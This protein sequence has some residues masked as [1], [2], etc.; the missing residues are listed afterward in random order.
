MGEDPLY[1][2][3]NLVEEVRGG[4]EAK[5]EAGIDIVLLPPAHTQKRPV[6]RMHR[7]HPECGLQV[8]LGHQGSWPQR[9]EDPHGVVDRGVVE[10]KLVFGDVVVHAPAGWRR[11]ME[12]HAPAAVLLRDCA[13][14][15]AV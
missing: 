7:N 11:E 1:C 12:Y 10:G 15:G 8:H 9:E 6:R 3:G 5:G 13:Q 2:R 14:A 4:P